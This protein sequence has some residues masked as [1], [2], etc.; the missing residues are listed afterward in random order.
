MRILFVDKFFFEF[1]GTEVYLFELMSMLREEGHETAVFSMHHPKNKPSEYERYFVPHVDFR[2]GAGGI[3]ARAAMAKR[4][5]YYREARKRLGRLI[6]DFRPDV[7]HLRNFYHHLSPS[8]LWELKARGVPTIYHINDF[9]IL[10]P[11]YNLISK[12]KVCE[13]CA[14]GKFWHVVTERCHGSSLF[15]N[16]T[17]CAEAYVHRW[18]GTYRKCVDLFIAPSRFA[19]KKLLEAALEP[20]KVEVLYHFQRIPS[21]KPREGGDPPILY[22]GRISAE[23]GVADLLRAVRSLPHVRLHVA[24]DGPLKRELEEWTAEKGLKNVRFLGNLDREKL[25]R[26]IARSRFTV[27]PSLV[28]E[29]LVKVILESYALERPVIATGLGTR[30]ELIEHGETGLLYPPSNIEELARNI[31]YL[32]ARPGLCREMGKKGKRIVL[33]RHSPE[34]HYRK[35]LSIY[36]KLSGG[37]K[38]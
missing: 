25:Y 17:L 4:V 36:E 6:R 21:E 35:I 31:N 33:E 22:F 18:L 16:L 37:K 2:N 12:G 26:E 15:S 9:K 8:I 5:V 7:A 10:C 32:H 20:S 29:T 13:K 1:S 14:G 34:A 27:M 28:Y 19:R 11:N 30:P 38:S 24:G 23:K 3:R